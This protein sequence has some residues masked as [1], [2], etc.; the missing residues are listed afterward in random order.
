MCLDCPTRRRTDDAIQPRTA[1]AALARSGLQ[2]FAVTASWRR[3]GGELERIVA[4]GAHD[5]SRTRPWT[6][7]FNCATP[8][9]CDR[10]RATSTQAL[11]LARRS[12]ERGEMRVD[13]SHGMTPSP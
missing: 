12:Y 6:P 4:G 5:S 9:A 3:G 1:F 8:L 13:H 2:R 7:S 11:P 10:G